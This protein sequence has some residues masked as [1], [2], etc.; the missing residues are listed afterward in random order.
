[1]ISIYRPFTPTTTAGSATAGREDLLTF[2]YTAVTKGTVTL[3]FGY[4]PWT[5]DESLKH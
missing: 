3:D 4:R 1:M 2:R 5:Q